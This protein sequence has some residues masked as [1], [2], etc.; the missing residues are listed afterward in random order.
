MA[1]A[2][3]RVTEQS[4]RESMADV[5]SAIAHTE[6]EIFNEAL[7]EAELDNDGDTELEEMGEGL[8]GEHLDE[9]DEEEADEQEPKPQESK[10]SDEETQGDEAEDEAPE[11]AQD[12]QEPETAQAPQPE[13]APAARHP[14]R[15]L[16]RGSR[17]PAPLQTGKRRSVPP[18]GRN[19]RPLDG[20]LCPPERA[21]ATTAAAGTAST[22]PKRASCL[23]ASGPVTPSTAAAA[24]TASRSSTKRRR[25]GYRKSAGRSRYLRTACRRTSKMPSLRLPL[26]SRRLARSISPTS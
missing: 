4:E 9:E 20:N 17:G 18:I 7:D 8:E 6:D 1:K 15:P 21:A 12:E 11:E 5:N 25:A 19:E 13:Q 23:L 16:A 14:A 24:F 10:P 22:A 2:P 3:Q 26:N